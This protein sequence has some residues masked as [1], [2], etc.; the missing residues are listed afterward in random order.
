MSRFEY[1]GQNSNLTNKPITSRL[2]LHLNLKQLHKIPSEPS[3]Q[4]LS[5]QT[6][7]IGGLEKW[8][9]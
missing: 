2:Y 1:L 8:Q 5:P 6:F 9:L 7:L 3:F 4:A